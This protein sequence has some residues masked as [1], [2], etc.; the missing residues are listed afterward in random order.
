[1]RYPLLMLLFLMLFVYHAYKLSSA[2]AKKGWTWNRPI[3]RISGGWKGWSVL[4]GDD[5]FFLLLAVEKPGMLRD[6]V[7][8]ISQKLMFSWRY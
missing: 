6:N 5:R 8:P 2:L 3:F 7:H 4:S 1:M